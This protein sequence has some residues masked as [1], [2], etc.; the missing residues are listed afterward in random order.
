VFDN[1]AFPL[2]EHTKASKSEIATRVDEQLE[3]LGVLHARHKLPSELSGGMRKR[4]AVARAMV[5]NPE[6]LIYDEPTRGLDPITSRTVDDLI[7]ATRER[8]GVTVIMISHDM[9]SVIDLAHHVSLL[10]EGRIVA[11]A[12]RDE[13]LASPDPRVRNFLDVSNVALP[14]EIE[15]R[16][17]R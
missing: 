6:I 9:K 3:A 1:V 11:S 7:V 15:A 2:R 12:A 17:R 14:P 4:V 5:I 13:F 16:V 8:T 10:K